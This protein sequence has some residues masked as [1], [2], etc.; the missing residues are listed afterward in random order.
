[1]L[2]QKFKFDMPEM[3]PVAIFTKNLS[4]FARV[5]VW[6]FATRKWEI[7]KDYVLYIS[8]LD[9]FIKI[10]KG[11]VF[12]GA[13]VPKSFWFLLSPT[14][15][16]LIPGLFHDF[17]YKY[18]CL[19]SIKDEILFRDKDQVFFDE[20]FRKL[21]LQVNQIKVPDYA[22]WFVLRCFGFIAYKKHRKED[23][24][25]EIDFNIRENNGQIY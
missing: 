18:N 5:K 17:G 8:H 3:R 14:G 1:M 20:L 11:F 2:K 25:V 15:I 13:S 16:L 23:S 22:S 19:I 4:I 21:S 6:L 12:D 7:T 9:K 24:K 10:P